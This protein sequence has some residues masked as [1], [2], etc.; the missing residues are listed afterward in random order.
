MKPMMMMAPHMETLAH[1]A[2]MATRPA[3]TPLRLMEMSGF[4]N[5]NQDVIMAAMAPAA[6]ARLVV[7]AM[8]PIASPPAVV[9]PGLNPNQ[10]NHRMN[11]PSAASG[12]L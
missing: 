1:P 9:L 10:P 11:T 4:L 5:R 6:A 8:K 12:M 2:V 3:S 7:M